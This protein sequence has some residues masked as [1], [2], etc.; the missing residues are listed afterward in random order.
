MV[1]AMHHRGP[2]DSGEFR[3]GPV[4]LG[5]ARLSILDLSALGHQPML[6]PDRR[7]GIVYNGELYNFRE[8]REIL[9][10]KGFVFHSNSDTEVVL[11]MYEC[12]GD[13]FVRRMLGIFALAIYDKRKGRGHERLLLARDH[14]GVKPLLYAQK[15]KG[16]VFAS[17]IKALLSSGLV[18][19]TVN[20]EALRQLL[21]F[22][23]VQQPMTML[24]GVRMLPPAHRL[25]VQAGTGHL[26][27]Y[28]GINETIEEKVN[29]SGDY[30]GQ[31]EQLRELLQNCVKSQMV[32]DVPVGAFLSGGLDSSALSALMMN[33][34]G[35]RVRTFSVG[36]EEEGSTIDETEDARQTAAHLGT[37]HEHVM[38][39][40]LDVRAD[41]ERAVRGLDQPSVDGFNSYMVSKAASRGVKVAISGTGG[42]E[43]FAGYP[44]FADMVQYTTDHHGAIAA[45]KTTLAALAQCRVFDPLIHTRG[46]WRLRHIRNSGGF[47]QRYSTHYNIYGEA[48]AANLL[49]TAG[50]NGL[51][52]SPCM[53][54]EIR[55]AD[56]LPGGTV[57]QRVSA[58]CLRGYAC[59]QLL[60][61][62][63][64]ASMAHS[65]EVRVPFLDPR[66]VAF[67]LA[68]PDSAKLDVVKARRGVAGRTYREMGTKRILRDAVADLLPPDIDMQVKRGFA[69]PFGNWLRGPLRDVMEDALSEEAVLRRGLLVPAAVQDVAAQFHAG[70]LGW[71]QPW[72][73]VVFELWCRQVLDQGGS[74]V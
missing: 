49:L 16:L 43:V 55:L 32:S 46:G 50:R 69:M 9:E 39:T 34:A 42:D 7:I 6:T 19:R 31:V 44:W 41:I 74:D 30:Q 15:G 45:A 8:E 20:P 54:E 61:D 17:E 63:D 29:L 73:L 64:A 13:D 2:D 51:P 53:A 4:V 58:L 35:G 57:I 38:V 47:R 22:G 27:R 62:I 40:G 26:E 5:M 71:A 1:K 72:L 60:R 25:V 21:T 23:S 3:D 33:A 48:G 14:F 10:S 70:R 36:F 18:S 68:L 12:Y 66:I 65:L 28:W 67:G 59:N 37:Q 52:A 56:E 11:R 24:D